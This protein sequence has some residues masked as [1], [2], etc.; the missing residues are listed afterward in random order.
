MGYLC[1]ALLLDDAQ[2]GVEEY[3]LVQA[4]GLAGALVA[5][6]PGTHVGDVFAQ[7]LFSEM[8]VTSFRI[9]SRRFFGSA[10]GRAA[11]PIALTCPA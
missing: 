1:R 5:G 2:M 8:C 3:H 6:T 4:P 9:P 10:H 7:A 11:L